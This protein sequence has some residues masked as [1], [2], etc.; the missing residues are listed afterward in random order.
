[1]EIIV[2]GAGTAVPMSGLSPASILLRT[3]TDN[4]LI[5]IGPGSLQKSALFGI[6]YRK[7]TTIFLT[8]LHP[9]HSLDLIT[10]LQAREFAIEHQA[11]AKLDIFGC[12]GTQVWVNGFLGL[13][14]SFLSVKNEFIIHEK[15]DNKWQWN[16]IDVSSMKTGHTENSIAF[17]FDTPD[18]SIVVS[19]DASPSDKL[20]DFCLGCDLLVCECSFPSNW[21]TQDHLNADMVGDLA[22]KSNTKHLV[23]THRYPPAFAVDLSSQIEKIYSGEISVAS[24]G[25]SYSI[26]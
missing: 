8:H 7:L 22:Q 13:Y 18:K 17:R 5:D 26:K 2:L 11:C 10:L 19:G 1:M 15:G 12:V 20:V 14:P 21:P 23:I 16:G 4:A 6:D 9:D 25:S 3:S 24:D